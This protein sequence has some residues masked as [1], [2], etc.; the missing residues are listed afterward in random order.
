MALAANTLNYSII[1][2]CVL[3]AYLYSSPTVI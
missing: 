1:C 3:P 2:T